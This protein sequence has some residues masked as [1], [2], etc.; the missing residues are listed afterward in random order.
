MVELSGEMIKRENGE[1]DLAWV[2]REG[3]PE[4]LTSE[5]PKI[6]KEDA[7]KTQGTAKILQ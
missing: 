3:F 7:R 5:I 6:N 4:A 2:V 1:T